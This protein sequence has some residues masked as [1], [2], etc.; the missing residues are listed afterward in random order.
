MTYTRTSKTVDA[1]RS[2]FAEETDT[3]VFTT[4]ISVHNKHAFDIADLVVR[5]RMPTCDDKRVKVI[6]R[7]PLALGKIKDG[8][9]ADIR[10][11]GLKVGWEKLV[12]GKGGEKEGKFEWKWKVTSGEKVDLFSEYEVKAP[13]GAAWVVQSV[14][15]SLFRS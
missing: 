1:E 4:K 2:S 7:H 8:A 5:D 11:D 3:T 15:P 13:R 14:W 12:D 9:Y 10:E 6:L